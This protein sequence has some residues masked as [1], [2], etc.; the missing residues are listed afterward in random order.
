MLDCVLLKVFFFVEKS[1]KSLKIT[2]DFHW[3]IIESA[4]VGALGKKQRH[5]FKG[6][7]RSRKMKLSLRRSEKGFTLI[8]LG[9]VVAVIAIL[10]TVVLFGRGFLDSAK[11]SKA[12]E[13][14]NTIRKAAS[15]YNGV[16]GGTAND[17]NA[18]ANLAL[19]ELIP[20]GD[21]WEPATGFTV[22]DVELVGGTKLGISISTPNNLAATDLADALGAD[23]GDTT[24]CT[25]NVTGNA[26]SGDTVNFCFPL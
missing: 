12:V 15:T 11:S 6:F 1:K 22:E 18:L 17:L 23:G 9:I 10:A 25:D 4:Q 20:E 24:N 5:V 19:R 2:L 3:L 16:K 21:G 8:E 7:L 13:A 14:V 26:A